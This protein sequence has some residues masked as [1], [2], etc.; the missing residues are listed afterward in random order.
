MPHIP[1]IEIQFPIARLSA[2]SYKERKA[3]S[4]Q[5]LTGLGKW[6]GRKPLILVRASLLGLLMPASGDPEK[7]RQIYYKI[8]TMDEDGL[9]RRKTKTMSAANIAQRLEPREYEGLIER[10]GGTASWVR[11]VTKADK[12]RLERIAFARL[13]YEEKLAY[14][15]RPE[16]IEG[17]SPEAWMDINAHLGTSAHSLPELFEQ[18]SQKAFGH[19]ARVGDCFCGGGSVPFEAARL[20][21]EAY[22]SDLNP[23]AVLL[24]WGAIN[25]IGGGRD[26]QEE[27]RRAQEAVWQK[28]DEQITAWGIEHDGRGNRADAYLYCV[29]ARCP[30]TGLWVPLAPS[31]VISE[32]YRVVAVL[33]R[34]D[35]RQGYDIDIISGASDEQMRRAKLGTI[36]DS[37]MIDPEDPSRRYSIASLRSDR[38]GP[39]GETIYGLRL[40]ENEDLVPRPD[41]IFQERLYSV[42]WVT[43]QGERV[44]KAVT[45]E[46]LAREQKVLE[47]LKERFAE[48]QEKG[49]IPSRK[50]P[51]GVE[52]SRLFRERGWTYWHHLFNP[53]QLLVHG[54]LMEGM[55][56]LSKR[57]ILLAS[58]L[59][60]IGRLN[61]WDSKL[62]QW[63]S[64]RP[65]EGS[66]QTFSNQA[67]N[68]FYNYPIRPFITTKSIIDLNLDPSIKRFDKNY[69]IHP[70]DARDVT[71]TADLWITDP[72]YADAVNYHE[73]ADFF[74][75]WYEKHLP[76]LFPDWYADSRAALAVRGADEDF[77]KSMVEIYANLARHMP[78]DGL[79][80][81]M[82]THQ[83]AGVWAD[84]GMIL[85][86]AGLRVTAAWTIGTETS[87]GLKQGNYVQGTVCLVLRKRLEHRRA[88][89]DELYP[90][91]EDEVKRQLDAMQAIDDTLQPQFG[92]T[93]YQLAAYAAAL[94]VLTSYDSIEGRDITHELFRTRA[95]NEASEFERIIDRAVSIATNYRIPR[96]ISS[97]S[98]RNLEAIERLYLAGLELERHGELRQGAYQELARGFGV[99]EYKFLLGDAGANQARFKTPSELKRLYLSASQNSNDKGTGAFAASLLRH[100]LFAIHEAVR[101][102][103][104]REGLNY[105]KAERLD[106]WSRRE[107]LIN[108][109][110]YLAAARNL[111]ALTYWEKDAESAGLLAGLVR[112]DYVGSR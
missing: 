16:E 22:G 75:A 60:S 106:Y 101:T 97:F 100:L 90:Q 18:L 87:S 89:I 33:R 73:L 95:K 25:L 93:D 71:Y 53:R 58:S 17:P 63:L 37:E 42:R 36:R 1:F 11:G 12:N 66:S 91:V 39:N 80:L 4:G 35:A 83:D 59:V 105:L 88:W 109:L 3:G 8:L 9:W 43:P 14:C 72:P 34:N 84:L 52:T 110:D 67:L 108:L 50:I 107:D 104:P 45:E 61:N 103:N 7:D 102:E 10:R 70:L 77:K 13:P 47:L 64:L 54:L 6:W 20:G 57:K 112:N 21:L 79:Q 49:Y 56:V 98:W 24:T 92:D 85:W 86:A 69:L 38:R 62:I 76:R 26:V 29:E 41:D 44:Y 19:R 2:E 96:G 30:A 5:T 78:D 81:V 23:V 55:G 28:V 31:W 99:A 74:L 65:G 94:R 48:W 27:V 32:K 68:T 15:C 51:E 82:F 111:S 46:D 40:W